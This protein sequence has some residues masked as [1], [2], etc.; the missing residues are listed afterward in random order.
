MVTVKPVSNIFV[1]LICI[2]V[3]LGGIV[4]SLCDAAYGRGV[5]CDCGVTKVMPIGAMAAIGIPMGILLALVLFLLGLTLVKGMDDGCALI[6]QSNEITRDFTGYNIFWRRDLK[7]LTATGK[8]LV[9]Y[10]TQNIDFTHNVADVNGHVGVR[11]LGNF[12]VLGSM[13]SLAKWLT[14]GYAVEKEA[15]LAVFYNILDTVK[16]EDLIRFT[17]S[18]RQ[19]RE[20]SEW[21]AGKINAELEARG[22]RLGMIQFSIICGK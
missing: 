2:S 17:D 1:W 3:F 7:R 20:F 18:R 10:A 19:Q 4:L 22:M 21:L 8:A 14:T 15:M 16:H 5:D 13:E 12:N 6:G 9:C 11:I